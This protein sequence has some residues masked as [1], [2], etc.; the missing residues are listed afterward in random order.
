METKIKNEIRS[1][2]VLDF[3]V[4]VWFV[5]VVL[6]QM[7]FAYYILFLYGKAGLQG[8]F[9]HWNAVTP[10]GHLANDVLGNVIF[11]MH[12]MLAAIITIGG[13]LQII[14]NVRN[15]LPTFHRISGRVYVTAAFVISMAGFYLTWVRG[16]VG[17]IEGAIF[18]SINGLIIMTCAFFAIRYAL[19]KKFDIHYRWALRLFLAMS[20][21][22]FFRVGMMFWLAIH[23]A[24]VGFDPETF[25]GP[26]L[27][28]LYMVTYVLPLAFLELYFRAK[29]SQ[30]KYPKWA[31]SL[32]LFVLTGGVAVGIFSATFGMWLPRL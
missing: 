13:P 8:N 20:G 25:R 4:L 22:Y 12:V 30:K 11:G 15:W 9:E 17:G 29:R 27:V 19:A 21:V 2:K 31:Y 1:I 23:Q 28:V 18:I 32:F 10:H 26:F 24:P 14:P 7:I 6:G 5:T 16:S 3:S